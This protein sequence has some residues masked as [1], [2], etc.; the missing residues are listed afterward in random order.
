VAIADRRCPL[1]RPAR[2]WR[3]PPNRPFYRNYL[4]SVLRLKDAN[5]GSVVFKKAKV[6]NSIKVSHR[7]PADTAITAP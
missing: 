3:W 4:P 6:F 1:Q 7:V 5:I 2:S